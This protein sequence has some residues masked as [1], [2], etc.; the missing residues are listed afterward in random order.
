VCVLT[1]KT[2]RWTSCQGAGSESAPYMY[3]HPHHALMQ[4]YCALNLDLCVSA[5]HVAGASRTHITTQTPAACPAGYANLGSAS[6]VPCLLLVKTNRLARGTFGPNDRGKTTVCVLP[7][8]TRGCRSSERLDAGKG[9]CKP[10]G[11]GQVA[12]AARVHCV[13][14]Q[15][16]MVKEPA[17][18]N[19]VNAVCKPAAPAAV[20]D[21]P[22]AVVGGP[23][24][25]QGGQIL[26]GGS[27]STCPGGQVPNTAG[28]ACEWCSPGA[29]KEPAA[30]ADKTA[31]PGSTGTEQDP[32]AKCVTAVGKCKSG[33]KAVYGFCESC[34]GGQVGNE[35]RSVCEWCPAGTTKYPAA[36]TGKTASPGSTGT[37]QVPTATCV[38]ADCFCELGDKAEYGFCVNCGSDGTPNEQRT[39]CVRCAAGT[40][41]SNGI[42]KH[43]TCP[44]GI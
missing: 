3:A 2:L 42:C 25:C 43:T 1:D 36:L 19:Q 12:D 13:R 35:T 39:S 31:P 27:C 38:S 33:E 30:S 5:H 8:S 18:S 41:A 6:C 40:E 16:G 44:A 10:C 15:A 17:G 37:E 7:G 29:I 14:C 22:T 11:S 4:R 28:S 32:A 34:P 9:V 20:E 26:V 24:T 21:P 23:P